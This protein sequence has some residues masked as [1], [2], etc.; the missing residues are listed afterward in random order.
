MNSPLLVRYTQVQLLIII[1]GCIFGGTKNHTA[2]SLLLLLLLL[3]MYSA[4]TFC[5]L[6]PFPGLGRMTHWQVRVQKSSSCASLRDYEGTAHPKS[7]LQCSSFCKKLGWIQL[8]CKLL[9]DRGRL[10]E[11]TLVNELYIPHK[12]RN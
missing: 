8:L 10:W 4:S 11:G 5:W 9:Q 2:D 6:G 12:N 3:L 1:L 7:I